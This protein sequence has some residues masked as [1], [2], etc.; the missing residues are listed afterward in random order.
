MTV[1]I[2]S[3][4]DVH[5]FGDDPARPL[6]LGGVVVPG[7]PGLAG[8]SDADVVAHAVADALLGAV[9]A[10]DLGGRFGVDDPATSG[11]DSLGLLRTVVADLAAD[12]FRV[13]NV[14]CTVVAQRPRLAGHRDA[15]RS[16]LAAALGVG[17]AAVS[18]KFTTTDGLGTLGRAE[19][20]ACW[21]S[22]LVADG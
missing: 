14:D 5:P 11:A 16:R 22:V 10:G 4:L 8:H 12:G 17:V 9:A 7:E 1:R 21:A 19:G 6:V 13:G 3:G 18:V 20:I 15:M 2:G